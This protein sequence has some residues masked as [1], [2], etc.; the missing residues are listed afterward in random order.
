[1]RFRRKSDDD[2][3]VTSSLLDNGVYNISE[4]HKRP[5]KDKMDK[6]PYSILGA[7]KYAFILTFALWWL[8]IIGPMIAGYVTGRR[9][10]KAWLGMLAATMALLSVSIVT[11]LLNS[12]V[13]GGYGSTSNLKDWLV[14]LIP[15]FGPYFEFADQYMS[16]YLGA[17]QLSTGMHLDIYILT[18]AFAYIGG[19]IATQTWAEMG[20]VSRHGGNNMTVAF[21]NTPSRPK[22]APKL[23]AASRQKPRSVRSSSRSFDNMRAV[24][25]DDHDDEYD[26]AVERGVERAQLK[27]LTSRTRSRKSVN[28]MKGGKNH[29][30]YSSKASRGDD[31]GD[32]RFL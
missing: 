2:D 20:Y 16:Y 13:V 5:K 6:S 15:I 22:K 17:V 25:E 21:H 11:T 31:K 4:S 10:G 12:G 32:W 14:A 8:P 28:S 1:M 18:L 24:T 7:I 26:D 29:G 30:P 19:A 9:A 27:E 23:V 3:E